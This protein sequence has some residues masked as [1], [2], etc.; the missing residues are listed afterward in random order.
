MSNS[1]SNV[2]SVFLSHSSVD[3]PFVR[4]LATALAEGGQIKVWLDEG[5][6]APGDNIVTKIAE[7]LESD[8]VL[9]VMSPDS[10]ASNWVREEWTD[11]YWE[12]TNKG[13]VK[14]KASPSV[15]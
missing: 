2:R 3:K 11:A 10:I 5:E 4:N 8:L 13:Q 14:Y 12:Q 1:D 6:I 15:H 9:F 7:G